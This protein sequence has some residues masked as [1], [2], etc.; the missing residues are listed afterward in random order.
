MARIIR[1]TESDL[2][3]IIRRVVLKEYY[4]GS[5]KVVLKTDIKTE[6]LMSIVKTIKSIFDNYDIN[7]KVDIQ[8][9]V[10]KLYDKNKLYN[11]RGILHP[12][13]SNLTEEE[14]DITAVLEIQEPNN[15]NEGLELLLWC[16]RTDES[17]ELFKEIYDTLVDIKENSD[18]FLSG[19]A[20]DLG[21]K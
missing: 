20:S 5:D 17:K 2:N 21:L 4:M 14:S 18:I 8:K 16:E 6:G 3:R 10:D 7:L 1:L 19:I 15:Q 12:E 11:N 9:P 13:L